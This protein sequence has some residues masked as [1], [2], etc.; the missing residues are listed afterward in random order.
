[1]DLIEKAQSVKPVKQIIKTN[2]K[3]AVSVESKTTI[4]MATEDFTR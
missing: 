4:L 2:G 1:M 3:I